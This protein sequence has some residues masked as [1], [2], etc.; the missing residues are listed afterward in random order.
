MTVLPN[1]GLLSR[2]DRCL[3]LIPQVKRTEAMTVATDCRVLTPK[4][5]HSAGVVALGA[6]LVGDAH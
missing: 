1:T 3:K 6:L 4:A 2:A 5:I